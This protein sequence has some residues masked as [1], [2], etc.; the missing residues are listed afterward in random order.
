MKQAAPAAQRRATSSGAAEGGFA[1]LDSIPHRPLS[2]LSGSV[3][4]VFAGAWGLLSAGSLWLL[5]QPQEPLA[6]RLCLVAIAFG[7]PAILYAFF[8]SGEPAYEAIRVDHDGLTFFD[9]GK[10][11]RILRWTDLVKNPG[12]GH[13]VEVESLGARV[14]HA[15]VRHETLRVW[16]SSVEG[17]RPQRLYFRGTRTFRSVFANAGELR[18]H[19]LAGVE[20]YRSRLSIDPTARGAFHIDRDSG[21]YDRRGRIVT[22][23]V[24]LAGVLVVVAAIVA[25]VD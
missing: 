21:A 13:D 9:R 18:A 12:S 22:N 20:T 16:V 5:F 19:F 17:P 24:A 2:L 14:G 4:L 1:A 8:R 11:V 10:L 15:R 23:A 25:F 6:L 3:A 7:T